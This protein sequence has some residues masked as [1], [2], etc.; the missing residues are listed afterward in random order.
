MSHV[1]DVLAILA[2]ITGV[3]SFVSVSPRVA[4]GFVWL[5]VAFI[6]IPKAVAWFI[7]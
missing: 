6:S 2:A 1:T 3:Y 4:M 7:G 5:T